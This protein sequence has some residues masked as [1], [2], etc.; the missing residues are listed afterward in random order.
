M[1]GFASKLAVVTTTIHRPDALRL[2]A[3]HAHFGGE[4]AFFVAGDFKTPEQ[5]CVDVVN[6]CGANAFYLS[7]EKQKSLGYKCSDLIGWGCI[8][9]RNIATL[10]ALKWGADILVFWDDDNLSIDNLYFNHFREILSTP[11]N[12]IAVSGYSNWFDVGQMFDPA[13]PHRGFP[14]DAMP[15]YKAAPIINAKVGVAAG[16][17]MGDPDVDSITRLANRAKPLDVHRCSEL[18]D[19]GFVVALQTK[20]VFNSQNS[21]VLRE[22][23]P[24]MLLVTQF[25]RF[26]DIFAS[27][28]TQKVMQSRGYHV[29]FGPPKIFQQRNPHNLLKDLDDEIWGM[30][31]ILNFSEAVANAPTIPSTIEHVQ[32]IYDHLHGAWLDCPP[33]VGRLADAWL[34]DVESVL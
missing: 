7:A 14:V 31:H 5:E 26:D 1:T 18:L 21:A 3:A 12:G 24:A 4:T 13:A 28:I 10:E 29:H 20:T 32:G 27:I 6:Q 23:A 17:C 16:T 9:R 2:L 15:L 22:F 25:K 11:F 30:K 33:G 19:A 8:Q 34:E